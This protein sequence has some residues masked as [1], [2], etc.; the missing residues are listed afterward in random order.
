MVG[1]AVGII[2]LSIGELIFVGVRGRHQLDRCIIQLGTP[3][4]VMG[5]DIDTSNF[6]GAFAEPKVCRGLNPYGQEM[7]PQK[8][9]SKRC[10][11]PQGTHSTLTAA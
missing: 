5:F 7:R 11:P 9:Q 10:T 1:K 8:S 3:G 2:Q 6:N 4:K